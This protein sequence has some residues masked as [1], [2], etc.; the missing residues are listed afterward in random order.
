MP[1]QPI[2]LCSNMLYITMTANPKKPTKKKSGTVAKKKPKV[3]GTQIF[4]KAP[5]VIRCFLLTTVSLSVTWVAFIKSLA[6]WCV[7]MTHRG[8]NGVL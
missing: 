7:G 2:L 3:Q 8:K 6:P 4:S 1:S 5:A